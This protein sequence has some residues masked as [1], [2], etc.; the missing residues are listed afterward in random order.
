MPVLRLCLCVLFAVGTAAQDSKP[1]FIAFEA[2]GA[3]TGAYLGTTAV[4]INRAGASAGYY[5]EAIYAFHGFVRS[6][7]GVITTFDPPGAGTAA[8][9]GTLAGDINAAGTIA[10]YYLDANLVFHA[11]VRA[12]SGGITTFGAPGA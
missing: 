1:T 7:D 6:A 5:T 4:S 10:A 3:G 8:N 2:P 12:A 9:Q 11:F